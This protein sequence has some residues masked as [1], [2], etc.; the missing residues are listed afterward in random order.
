MR[1]R[2]IALLLVAASLA[3]ACASRRRRA[4]S[5]PTNPGPV[6]LDPAALTRAVYVAVLRDQYFH[7]WLD[8]P[9]TQVAIDPSVAAVTTGADAF[10]RERFPEVRADALADYARPRPAGTVPRDLDP[11]VPVRWFSDADFGRLPE[12]GPNGSRWPAF[13]RTFPGSPGHITLSRV[14]LSS[15]GTE[16][17][18]T[19]GCWFD[20]VGGA[21]QLVLL[22]KVRGAWRVAKTSVTAVS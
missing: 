15:D 17:L 9:V 16:A 5:P 11:G 12:D 14:G 6:A 20:S 1:T 7:D 10:V 21:A 8:R 22:R 4:P 13:H 3:P 19:A 18:L 2:G